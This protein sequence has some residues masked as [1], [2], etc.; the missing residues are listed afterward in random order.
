[1]PRNLDLTAL[2]SFLTVVETGGVT[3]AA[4]VLNL[5]QSAVSMQLKRLEDSL[6]LSL[7]DRSGRG[8]APTP[9]GEQLAGYARRILALND[10]VFGRLT[11]TEYEGE[12][13]LGL[14]HDI[15]YPHIP[16][17]LKRF[18]TEFPR[19][20]VQL[21]SAP[22]LILKAQMSRGEVDVILTTET[23]PGPGGETL[24]DLPVVWVGAEGGS[25][26]RERPL[27]L[28]MCSNCVFRP[29]V[30]RALEDAGIP[31]ISAVD[32]TVDTA[33]DA[34]VGADLA[35][36]AAIWGD[37]PPQTEV[38]DHGG[39]LPDLGRTGIVLYRLAPE[40]PVSAA[41]GDMLRQVYGAARPSASR[42]AAE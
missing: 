6:G 22:S 16:K 8:I 31:W 18:S 28:A 4:G 34:A 27:R 19:M 39:A 38:I 1:M 26:W 20:R 3:R 24:V 2:R 5:T 41:M 13:R 33:V 21:V 40:D 11:A 23:A 7:L 29:N 37:L 30:V 14:P 9:A 42:L 25:I 32:S 15:I 35:V 36:E 17:V 10:E 12:L